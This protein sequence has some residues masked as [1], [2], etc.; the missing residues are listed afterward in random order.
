MSTVMCLTGEPRVLLNNHT[1]KTSLIDVFFDNGSQMLRI[2]Y[3]LKNYSSFKCS[4]IFFRISLL[5]LLFALKNWRVAS[6]PR[7]SF[8][9]PYE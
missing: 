3:N 2:N 4:L 6:Y 5:I 8:S 7:P 1:K 9:S